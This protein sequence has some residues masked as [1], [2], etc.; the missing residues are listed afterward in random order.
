MKT[1]MTRDEIIFND[2]LQCNHPELMAKALKA[3]YR[4]GKFYGG[5][6]GYKYKG[7]TNFTNDVYTLARLFENDYAVVMGVKKPVLE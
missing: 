6:Y 5:L 4:Y 2:Y 3:F 1:E 7:Y